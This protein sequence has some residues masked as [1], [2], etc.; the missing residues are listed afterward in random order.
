MN[1]HCLSMLKSKIVLLYKL[2]LIDKQHFLFVELLFWIVRWK[3]ILLL[4]TARITNLSSQKLNKI[5]DQQ[6][7]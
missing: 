1:T 3:D 7:D 5:D 2:V 6:R 4:E